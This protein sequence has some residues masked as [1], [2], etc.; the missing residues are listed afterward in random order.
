MRAQ[1][2][3]R[4]DALQAFADELE[5]KARRYREFSRELQAGAPS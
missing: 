5:E 2:R 4:I 3:R 1:V